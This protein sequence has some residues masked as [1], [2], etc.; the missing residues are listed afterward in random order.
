[1]QDN[2]LLNL[3]K[4]YDQK[5][6]EVLALNKELVYDITK[7]KLNKTIGKMWRPKKAMLLIGVPYTLMLYIIT[8]IAYLAGGFF[9]TIGFG[10]IALI[11]TTI[12]ILYFY[13]LYLIRRISS[14]DEIVYVQE[15]LSK[16]KLSSFNCARIAVIQLPFW[17]VC[18]L[19]LNALKSSPFLY[20]GVNVAVFSGLAYL[21]YW[22]YK[23]LSVQNSGSK[24][25]RFFLSGIEWDPIIKSS[26]ILEQLKAY[27][28]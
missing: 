7:R 20:G 3:W 17:V 5:I 11:M 21:S 28:N 13:H 26:E 9:V 10:A 24:V 22:L 25:S 8:L 18:W 19:S 14:S 15:K 27:K 23:S 4:S 2:E 12:V 6:G 1:M 16:L